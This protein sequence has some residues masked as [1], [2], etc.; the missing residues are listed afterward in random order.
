MFDLHS[1]GKFDFFSFFFCNTN[2]NP[3]LYVDLV[4]WPLRAA[5][6]CSRSAR[7]PLSWA[8]QQ[9]SQVY[10]DG[11]RRY[12]KRCWTKKLNH[13][14]IMQRCHVI[15]PGRLLTLRQILC[16]HRVDVKLSAPEPLQSCIGDTG[17][18]FWTITTLQSCTRSNEWSC[19]T[20]PR[21]ACT[22][23][24]T[25]ILWLSVSIASGIRSNA[26]CQ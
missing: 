11:V 25:D 23:A 8:V 6:P 15:D 18:H 2:T 4:A 3:V 19:R 26:N 14:A 16:R 13:I 20:T 7:L 1:S 5:S 24:E 22:P 9:A 21:P 17:K 12:S 10:N